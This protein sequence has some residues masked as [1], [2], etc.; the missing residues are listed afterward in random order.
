MAY[1]EK[2]RV[3]EQQS[4]SEIERLLQKYKA[5][6]VA[7]YTSVDSIAIAFEMKDRRVMFRLAMPKGDDNR[8][9]QGR[10]Q[11]WRS[12]LLA[13]KAKLSSVEDGIESFEDAFLAHIVMPDGSTVADHVRPRIASAYKE[14]RMQPLLPPPTNRKG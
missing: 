2:T 3:P 9:A 10:R 13:I 14:G 6:A 4:R 12:L 7:V 8:S 11:R 5:T 1:A